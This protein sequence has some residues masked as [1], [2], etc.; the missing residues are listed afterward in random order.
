MLKTTVELKGPVFSGAV[1]DI[2]RDGVDNVEHEI[3]KAGEQRLHQLL[4][5]GATFKPNGQSTGAYNSAVRTELVDGDALITDGGMVYGPWLE[6][7]SSRNQ[8]TRFKGYATFRKTRDWLEGQA[9]SIAEAAL[10]PTMGRL[11]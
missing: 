4:V 10:Q 7:T 3:A 11:R 9:K 2:I 5:R 1:P 8:S 6:G